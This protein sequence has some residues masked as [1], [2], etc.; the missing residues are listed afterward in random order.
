MQRIYISTLG[1]LNCKVTVNVERVNSLAD[2]HCKER[3]DK[4]KSIA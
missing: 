2:Y 1:I 4:P 3:D